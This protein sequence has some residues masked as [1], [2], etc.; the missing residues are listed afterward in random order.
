MQLFSQRLFIRPVEIADAP[1]ILQIQRKHR[2]FFAPYVPFNPDE[3]YTLEAQE[4]VVMVQQ[5]QWEKDQAYAFAIILRANNRFLGRISLSNV[6]RGPWQNATVGY[7]LDPEVHHQGYATEA[8]RAVRDAAFT[9]LTLHRIQAAVM[10]KN[11]ASQKVVERAD[12]HY[13]GYAP[14]YLKINRV[15]EGHNIYSLTVEDWQPAP[16]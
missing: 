8:L 1:S 9:A 12:F 5:Q 14:Y 2:A 4:K 13:E 10:P 7:W 15:W 11:L 6:V 3:F 16:V